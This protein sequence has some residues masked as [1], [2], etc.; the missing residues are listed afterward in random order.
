MVG[1]TKL[2]PLASPSEAKHDDPRRQLQLERVFDAITDGVALMDRTWHFTFLNRRA[3]EIVANGRPIVGMHYYEVFPDAPG[4]VFEQRYAEAMNEGRTVEFTDYYAPLDIWAAIRVFPIEDGIAIFFQ[5]VTQ[6]R[7]AE[8]SS[9]ESGRRLR[10]ALDAGQLGTWSW[11]RDTDMLDLDERAA[12][13]YFTEPHVPVGRS[14]MR[15]RI[16]APE[17]RGL[18]SENLRRSLED[19]GLYKAE[20]RILRPG[21]SLNDPADVRWI[22]ASGVATFGEDATKVSGMVGT[23]QDIT[24][25]RSQ[26]A[27][28]RQSEKLAATGRLAATIAH[29]INNPLEAVTNLIYLCKT[30]AKVP[31]DLKKLLE[32][33]DG[34]LAR[35]SQIAQQTLGFYRD[36]SNPVV[37]DMNSLIEGVVDLFTRKLS[38][39]SL[40]CKVDLASDLSIT[41]LQGEIRQVFSNLFVNAIDASADGTIHIRGRRCSQRGVK[42]VS[43]LIN[44]PGTGIPVRVRSNLFS[45]FFTTKQ[46]VGTGLGLWVTRGIVEKHGGNVIFRTRTETPTGT[47]FRVFLPIEP[48]IP[49]FL[50]STAPIIQ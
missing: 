1:P 31:S 9:Q 32:I 17:D 19:G 7:R 29:E 2:S 5:D 47:C 25:R 42:G 48:I 39:K 10:Q 44:D 16:V 6:Q 26:E 49:A 41:G 20:Y 23:V 3:M 13:L 15:D 43:I 28:L 18:T 30:D 33:A 24:T 4:S 21:G 40:K 34:E 11:D 36:T 12:E 22:S 46:S 14:V 27:T 37:I 45:P 38:H 50:A 35:I 8:R